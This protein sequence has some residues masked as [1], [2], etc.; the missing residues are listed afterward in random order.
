MMPASSFSNAGDIMLIS[1]SQN[2]GVHVDYSTPPTLISKTMAVI[3][4]MRGKPKEGNHRWRSNKHYKQN[5]GVHKYNTT[6]G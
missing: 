6:T 2:K 3:A 1:S 4:M 5:R